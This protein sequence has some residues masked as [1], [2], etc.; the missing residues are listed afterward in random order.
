[1]PALCNAIV[2]QQ[3]RV[4]YLFEWFSQF[5][6]YG[7]KE[8]Q[9]HSG[10]AVFRG[11]STL[12]GC[13][14]ASK[15]SAHRSHQALFAPC[16]LTSRHVTTGARG[17]GPLGAHRQ[18]LPPERCAGGRARGEDCGLRPQPHGGAAAVLHQRGLPVRGCHRA[19]PHSLL[20]SH[21]S[22]IMLLA[23]GN[24]CALSLIHI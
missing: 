13:T 7:R 20:Q 24:A 10:S 1:M 18:Q 8:W 22:M 17:A 3:S 11:Y 23:K 9:Q 5:C 4:S 12:H 16:S 2:S 19:P 14:V 6:H 21:P 15:H